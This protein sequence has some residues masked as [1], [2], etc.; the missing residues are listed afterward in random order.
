MWCSSA[1]IIKT[2]KPKKR[3]GRRRGDYAAIPCRYTIK[4]QIELLDAWRQDGKLLSPMPSKMVMNHGLVPYQTTKIELVKPASLVCGQAL[5]VAV[6]GMP[7]SELGVPRIVPSTTN[8]SQ[9]AFSFSELNLMLEKSIIGKALKLIK[10][11][12]ELE[13]AF[14]VFSLKSGVYSIHCE[15]VP[16]NDGDDSVLG[17]GE[18][19]VGLR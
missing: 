12:C 19:A 15:Y 13:H 2:K 6:S 18:D 1:G 14:D 9:N 17:Y 3:E 5:L 11:M 16:E 7:L 4:K 8:P 10:P